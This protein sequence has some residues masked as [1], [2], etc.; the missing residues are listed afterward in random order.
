MKKLIL[1]LVL[2]FVMVSCNNKKQEPEVIMPTT[3]YQIQISNEGI[4]SVKTISA[5]DTLTDSVNVNKGDSVKIKF[6]IKA[7][8]IKGSMML[9]S[10]SIRKAS[11]GS[12]IYN[13]LTAQDLTTSSVLIEKQV[14]A[15]AVGLNKYD[16]E[17]VYNTN[18]L[19]KYSVAFNVVE[20]SVSDTIPTISFVT[21]LDNA[22]LITDST[23]S[24]NVS[25]DKG[26]SKVV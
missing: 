5:N 16:I 18:N 19:I 23:L 17:T 21:P 15:D 7:S 24:V 6:T 25:D 11:D 13:D 10:V 2:I 8:A 4:G 26:I 20:S 3:D 1:V 14:T 9:N 22:V 12:L